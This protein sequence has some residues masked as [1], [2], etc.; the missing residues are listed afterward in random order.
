MMKKVLVI[1]IGGTFIKYGLIDTS[2]QLTCQGKVSTP[3]ENKEHFLDTLYDIYK[4]FQH[5]IEGIAISAPGAIDVQQGYMKTAGMLV[6]LNGFHIVEELSKRC[7]NIKV[8]VENDARSA[9][10][11][12]YKLGA[13]KGCDSLVSIIFGSGIGGGVILDGKLLYGKQIIAG[14]FSPIFCNMNAQ[15]YTSLASA[16]STLTT[17]KRLQDRKCDDTITGEDMMRLYR[18]QDKDAV[19]VVDEWFEVVAK[20]CYNIDCLYNPDC[21]CIGGGISLDPLFYEGIMKYIDII[22]EKAYVFR[23]PIVKVCS[24]HNDANL[25]GAYLTYQAS[26]GYYK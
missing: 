11:C 24:Y 19:E 6:Y 10:L 25:L 9:T 12:E 13:G 16:Y 18:Q 22:K 1:D 23:K 20:W 3:Y 26:S 5:E 15:D 8:T 2:Y 14:E 21:I 4:I 7:N 17:V